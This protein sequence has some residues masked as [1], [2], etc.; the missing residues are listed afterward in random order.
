MNNFIV[1][2][3]KE[4]E[5]KE[6]TAVFPYVS[7][8]L[9]DERL[10][11]AKV[12][13]FSRTKA[14]LPLT[15]FRITFYKN[16]D[17][18]QSDN[19]ADGKNVEYFILANDN[20]AEYP[21]GSGKY[22]H[23]VYLIERTKL[24][25]GVL[26]PSLTFT[27]AMSYQYSSKI[28]NRVYAKGNKPDYWDGAGEIYSPIYPYTE[29]FKFTP[30]SS[31]YE[32]D[33]LL[34]ALE[35]N[36]GLLANYTKLEYNPSNPSHKT[37]LTILIDGVPF[38]SADWQ[39]T[40]TLTRDDLKGKKNIQ[41][42]YSLH[43]SRILLGS[44][45][46]EYL[47]YFPYYDIN[48][49]DFKH[50][51]KPY[52]IT[53]C[54]NRVLE[55]AEPLRSGENPRFRFDG[56]TYKNGTPTSPE[57]YPQGTQA[58]KYEKI[59][60]PEF[61]M[62][63]STLREQ[64]KVIG[65]YI[66]AEPWLDEYNVIHFLEYGVQKQ[67]QK[68][69]GIAGSPYISNT[70]KTDINQYCTDIKSNAQNLVSSLGFA[71]GV[72]TD[73]SPSLYRSLRSE[74]MYVR[75]NEE[76]GVA[77][78]VY[79]IY[80]IEKVMCGISKGINNFGWRYKPKDITPYVFEATEYGANLNSHNGG[81]PYSKEWAIYYTQGQK[82]LQGL[83][84]QAPDSKSSAK[85]SPWAIAN[86]LAAVN[87]R[88]PIDVYNEITTS[89][90]AL[91]F[92]ITYKPIAPAFISHGKQYY[93]SGE[94]PYTQIYNQ[95]DNLIET[96]YYGENMK[97]VAARLGNIEQTRT[98][99]LAFR[100]QIPKTGEMIDGYAISAVHVEYMPKYIKCTL[101]LSKDFNRISEYVGI[102]SVKRMYEISERQTS[103]RDILIKETVL[104]S[105]TEEKNA[106]NTFFR[107]ITGFL[108]A[109]IPSDVTF[110]GNL[111][112]GD[113]ISNADLVKGVYF[114]GYKKDK[115]SLGKPMFL[116]CIGR[117]FGNSVH[118]A[119]SM[120]DNY[121]AGDST[122]YI[123]STDKKVDGLWQTDSPYT[124]FY[125]RIYW[126][127][128][129]LP[130]QVKS[131]VT[132]PGDVN[133]DTTYIEA[134]YLPKIAKQEGVSSLQADNFIVDKLFLLRKDNRE[135]ISYNIEAEYKTDIE[136]LI[137][138]SELAARCRYINDTSEGVTMCLTKQ[139]VN[140][141]GEYF[142]PGNNDLV[143]M[144]ANGQIDFGIYFHGSTE[145][146]G[147]SNSLVLKCNTEHKNR[148]KNF[149][150]CTKI[151]TVKETYADENGDVKEYTVNK[152]GKIL[153]AGSLDLFSEKEGN[154][155]IQLLKLYF[156]FQRS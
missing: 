131:E 146:Q 134:L 77:Q 67:V 126:A 70:L 39:N 148:Y 6:V 66:H 91:V 84:Y 135:I 3:K 82:N 53:D 22:R 26:C 7:G 29:E 133:L 81:Y 13:F 118:F 78:T 79:P 61:T 137:I 147:S 136:G 45:N 37:S 38:A 155:D 27:N 36:E 33:S 150:I 103:L 43:Y 65:S 93:I 96:Q 115:T 16:Q 154:T 94:T 104:I 47:A 108:K 51:L 72:I 42:K 62:T 107:S 23:E 25:E 105:K 142:T 58:A 95:G 24:L 113:F 117:S 54:V 55:L 101:G 50:P 132:F 144:G 75:V 86:I 85:Y 35:N 21:A 98:Y 18:N 76:N 52:T 139:D 20:S 109:F 149:V 56:V 138:G 44:G 9:L 5:W 110:K 71:K 15:E 14:Y 28:R 122:E 30:P 92:Q 17:L 48:I 8:D 4:N 145:N 114:E 124:D 152:G 123:E 111:Y 97:G 151:E 69:S 100:S 32:L 34:D 127:R 143:G 89:A 31:Y 63:Q 88:A 106:E 64:L 1:E 49:V 2:V 40:I 130:T 11:E 156:T 74:T 68:Q 19:D 83:F 80:S 59:Q 46:Y 60:A 57:N 121:S 102:S 120:K 90:A 116:P 87:G 128:I 12:T 153:L 140:K 73:P 119:M 125:G 10:D 112:Q 41:L 99:M 129:K 141:F